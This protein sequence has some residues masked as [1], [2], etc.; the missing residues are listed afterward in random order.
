M[1]QGLGGNQVNMSTIALRGASGRGMDLERQQGVSEGR[2]VWGPG[3]HQ[4]VGV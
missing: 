3:G 2:V 1:T 4:G